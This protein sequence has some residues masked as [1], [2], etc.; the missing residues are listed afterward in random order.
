MKVHQGHS[1]KS[2]AA[3]VSLKD[4][5]CAA[6]RAHAIHVQTHVELPD[7]RSLSCP[8]P[9]LCFCVSAVMES[10]A[11]QRC[12]VCLLGS[13]SL[14]P[15]ASIS[16]EEVQSSQRGL[17]ESAADGESSCSGEGNHT[18]TTRYVSLLESCTCCIPDHTCVVGNSTSV[19]SY[20]L[21]QF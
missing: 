8:T 9:Q 1:L 2:V 10:G 21:I 14:R 4:K 18:T 20:M 13:T 15:L 16:A 5:T 3:Q 11:L 19:A 17:R 7:G 6:V 12:C